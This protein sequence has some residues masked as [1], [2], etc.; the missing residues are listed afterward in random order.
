SLKTTGPA[1]GPI[2]EAT[3]EIETIQLEAGDILF[4]YTDGV[5]EARSE[6]RDF[7]TRAR[8]VNIIDKGCDVSAEAFLETIKTDLFSFIGNAPQSDDITMLA[9]KWHPF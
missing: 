1:L 5:T 3:Y 4:A 8:L 7:Y 9:V 2:Q 6:T